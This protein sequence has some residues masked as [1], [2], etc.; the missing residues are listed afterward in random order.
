MLAHLRTPSSIGTASPPG[1][2]ASPRFRA[3]GALLLALALCSCG[4]SGALYLPEEGPPPVEETLPENDAEGSEH[5]AGEES[6][7]ALAPGLPAP[8]SP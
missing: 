1:I 7:D 2:P 8:D 3:A 5:T 6:G 4:F